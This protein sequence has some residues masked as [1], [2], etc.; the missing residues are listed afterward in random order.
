MLST[1]LAA[2]IIAIALYRTSA[3]SQTPQ[4]TSLM[5]YSLQPITPNAPPLDNA[6]SSFSLYKALSESSLSNRSQSLPSL[7]EKTNSRQKDKLQGKPFS[8]FAVG[9]KASTLGAGIEAATPLSSSLNLRASGNFIDWGYS[10][11]IDGINY[12]TQINFRSGQIGVDWFPFHG[13]F[14]ISPG[15]LYFKNGLSGIA[16][17]PPGQAFQLNNTSYIN[18]V[19]DPVS[20]T[21]SVTY[22]QHIAPSLT[23]GFSNIIPRNGK[24]FNIPF[25]VGAAYT[26]AA[27]MNIQLDGTACTVQGCFNAATDPDTQVNLQSEIKQI[28]QDVK[29]IPVFPILSLGLAFRF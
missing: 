13:G 3:L 25:E 27:Y 17:V 8:T 10:F 9:I 4:V 20:G 16:K 24:H 2:V 29:K 11:N 6:I 15:I 12:F 21:A 28:N 14:H 22:S 5:S 18:S 19:D 1:K 26:R 7:R 23:V